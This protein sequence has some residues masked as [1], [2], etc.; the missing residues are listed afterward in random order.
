MRS[1]GT[2]KLCSQDTSQVRM[3]QGC[4]RSS[5][6]AW[7]EASGHRESFQKNHPFPCLFYF[8]S[9]TPSRWLFS[10]TVEIPVSTTGYRKNTLLRISPSV[11]ENPFGIP[12][13]GIVD[14]TSY[15]L[16]MY[17]LLPPPQFCVY[18]Q[19]LNKNNDILSLIGLKTLLFL[20][21][22][23]TVPKILCIPKTTPTELLFPIWSTIFL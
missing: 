2:D 9:T 17:T 4:D 13:F 16:C 23:Q 21:P 12:S 7:K 6:E 20:I 3:L 15:I 11:T 10:L 5:S 22:G 8:D 19:P 14:Y 1:K 18:V